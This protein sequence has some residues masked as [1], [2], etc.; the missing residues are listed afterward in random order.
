[1]I[2][3]QVRKE[4]CKKKILTSLL[5]CVIAEGE[6]EISFDPGNIIESIEEVTYLVKGWCLILAQTAECSVSPYPFS[7][8]VFITTCYICYRWT[9]DG[10][11]ELVME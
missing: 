6:D 10:G 8:P 7:C 1:M 5:P 4:K 2:I 11:L 3:K 9:K